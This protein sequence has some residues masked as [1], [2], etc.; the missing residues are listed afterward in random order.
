MFELDNLKSLFF[1]SIMKHV[2]DTNFKQCKF[3]ITIDIDGKDWIFGSTGYV[4]AGEDE[5]GNV[6][7]FELS[8]G[9]SYFQFPDFEAYLEAKYVYEIE[10]YCT[11]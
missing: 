6:Q 11:E 10:K 8:I 9:K 5:N 2:T 3:D 7:I 4:N 1:A